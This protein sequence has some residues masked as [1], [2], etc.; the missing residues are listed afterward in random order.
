MHFK[1]CAAFLAAFAIP[2]SAASQRI[3]AADTNQYAMNITV[4]L[5]GEQKSISPYIYGMNK[6][7]DEAVLDDV[8][9]SAVR[10]GGNRLTAY[11]WETN[12]SNAGED[13]KHSSDSF[14]SSSNEPAKCVQDFSSVSVK[15]NIPYRLTTLQ[16]AGYV[17]ADKNGS[18]SES[19]TAPSDRWN[20]V[21]FTKGSALSMTPDLTDGTVYMDEYVNYIVN[22]LGDASSSTG[23]QGYS[24]DNE[25]ALWQHTHNRMHPNA[26]TVTELS[27][28][29]IE[30]AKAVKSIDPQG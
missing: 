26:V 12:A 4:D 11:N 24:L 14:M 25:P 19:E 5:S 30:L 2:L 29:S 21:E 23:I 15:H 6:Y 9:V 3:I 16:M 28:K 8:R 13:W 20:K 1:R 17:A 18:V 7:D 27:D 22:T 10:Q